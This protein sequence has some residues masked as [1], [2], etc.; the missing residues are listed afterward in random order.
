MSQENN[1]VFYGS[2]GSTEIYTFDENA[3]QKFRKINQNRNGLIA[4]RIDKPSTSE[5]QKARRYDNEA[6]EK[7]NP[8]RGC[9]C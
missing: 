6:K 7:L 2:I 5:K 8:K 3:F 9:N 4:R 1:P